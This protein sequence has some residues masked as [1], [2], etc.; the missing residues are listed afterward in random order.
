MSKYEVNAELFLCLIKHYAMKTHWEL[1]Y[2][3]K[4]ALTSMISG[5][6]RLSSPLEKHSLPS[7]E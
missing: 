6:E 1:R 2:S 7:T 3:S 5:S 4:Q